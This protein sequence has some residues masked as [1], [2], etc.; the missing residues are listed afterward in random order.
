MRPESAHF[1]PLEYWLEHDC[2]DLSD[3]I[4]ISRCLEDLAYPVMRKWHAIDGSEDLP[5]P[6]IEEMLKQPE[7]DLTDY[8]PENP[9]TGWFMAELIKPYIAKYFADKDY[10]EYKFSY[11]TSCDLDIYCEDRAIAPYTYMGGTYETGVGTDGKHYIYLHIEPPHPSAIG[12]VVCRCHL[13][14]LN[15]TNTKIQNLARS[16]RAGC[17]LLSKE[18]RRDNLYLS[19]TVDIDKSKMTK[20]EEKI[21]RNCLIDAANHFLNS[22]RTNAFPK[23]LPETIGILKPFSDYAHRFTVYFI[24]H[25]HMDLAWKWRYPESVE[26]MKGTIENQLALMKKN[27]E[28]VY[29][30]T[31]AVMWKDLKEKYPEFWKDVRAAA[32][33]GQ[34]EPQGGMWCETDGQCVGAESWFRQLEYGQRAALDT[35]GKESTVGVNVDAF[36]FNAAFPKILKAAGI[37]YFVTQKLRYNEKTLFPYIHFW[38]EADD[39]SRILALHEYPGHAN[40]IEPDELAK[41][42]CIHHMTDGFYHI[43]FTWGYGNHGGGPLPGMMERLEELRHQTIFPNIKYSGFT[44][45]YKVLCETEDLSTLPVVKGELFLETHQKTFTVQSKT[46]YLN[47]EC[48]RSL[49][50]AESLQAATDSF[51]NLDTAWE[52]HLF[53]QFHDIL[54]GTSFREVYEDVYDDYNIAFDNIKESLNLS[55]K[56]ALGEGEDYYIFNPLSFNVSQPVVLDKAPQND[57]G[58]LCD[59]R[60]NKVSYQKTHDNKTV[61]MASDLPAFGFENYKPTS[62]ETPVSLLKVT[63]NTADNG[64]FKVTFDEKDGLISSLK[65]KDKEICGDRIGKLKVF[66]DTLSRDY[67]SWNFGFT[68]KEWDVNCESF[69]LIEK[70]PVRAVFR[71]KFSFGNWIDKKPYFGVYL[72]HTPAVEYPTSFFTQDFIIYANDPMIR[73]EFFAE[74]WEDR[75]V[76]KLSAETNLENPRAFYQVPFGEIERPVKRETPYEKARFEVPAITYGDLR[77]DSVGFALLNRSKHGYDTLGNRIRLTLLTSPFGEDKAKVPDPTADRGKHNFE[78]AFMPHALDADMKQIAEQYERSVLIL[79]GS[80][81]PNI[82]LGKSLISNENIKDWIKSVRLLQNGK[83]EFRTLDKNGSIHTVY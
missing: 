24:G 2:K 48:E 9:K 31:S 18:N 1:K 12:D 29:M 19:G 61:F 56:K 14:G 23:S 59:S 39:S 15:E 43:P 72:W 13:A 26:C 76:L 21:F 69:E 5:K 79:K 66:E 78:F 52:K 34:F 60:G 50:N 54:A 16:L 55:S 64:I 36:G 32:E 11:F 80:E 41:M 25:A 40:H 17:Y 53:N 63:K 58:C 77:N 68:G 82:S 7:F 22:M 46:K 70:G 27:P 83:T 75:K 6:S 74:W 33:R 3:V 44:E 49:L 4:D 65:F 10:G 62:A 73:C 67:D 30:E 20:E 57:S 42:I 35:C 51:C 8:I 45:F 28:Y 81:K 71:A 47:R 38:W 37:P